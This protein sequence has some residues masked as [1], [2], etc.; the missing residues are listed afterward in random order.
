MKQ[1]VLE[2]FGLSEQK[3][4]MLDKAWNEHQLTNEN[5][6][7]AYEKKKAR[8]LNYS[9]LFSWAAV[10]SILFLI[11]SRHN[12]SLG[13]ISDSVGIIFWGVVVL[14]GLVGS[15]ISS[16]LVMLVAKPAI[17]SPNP[18]LV[19]NRAA[20][21][22]YKKAIEEW[23]KYVQDCEER[24][25]LR[26]ME[27]WQS[28]DGWAF[29][30]NI[31]KLFRK[32]G[33][34]AEVTKGSGDEGVDIILI[35][36]NKTTIVQCKQHSKPVGP[37]VVRDL[38]GALTH[39]KAKNAILVSTSGFTSGTVSFAKNK[40]ITLMGMHEILKMADEVNQMHV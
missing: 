9:I 32:L 24:E 17:I 39:F 3:I 7:K 37:S 16:I 22:Q 28:M 10:P 36:D 8:I 19:Q 38:F 23:K 34:D 33:F 12:I 26:K 18:S 2:D 25:Q 6:I 40:P 5:A 13:K 31:G 11:F 20:Y 27:Y 1:P 15:I 35:K 4:S 29:E 14:S 30:E 21:D